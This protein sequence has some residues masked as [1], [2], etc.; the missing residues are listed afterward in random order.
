[1]GE[2]AGFLAVC[3]FL[4]VALLA[5]SGFCDE[6]DAL[7]D[8][9][10][11][12]SGLSGQLESFAPAV[13]SAVPDDAFPNAKTKAEIGASMKKTVGKDRL[14]PL[15]REA[16]RENFDREMIEQ[17]IAFYD[18]KL[19][20]K[21]GRLQGN[22]LAPALLKTVREGRKTTAAM[23]E[24]RLNLLRR[25]IKAE[26]VAQYNQM[27]LQSFVK[28]LIDAAQNAQGSYDPKSRAGLEGI[29]KGIRFDEARTEEIALVALT[30]AYRSLDDKELEE[31]AAHKESK[32][33]VWFGSTLQKGL[34]KAAYE[35]GKAL[36]E[37]AHKS[38]KR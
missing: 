25:I 22:I 2:W 1:M 29:E 14:L 24:T 6:T 18:S 13:L 17:V 4:W 7:I 34:D 15:V 10:L 27:L 26:S 28:G 20:R 8:K 36:G 5:P 11:D 35:T 16:V 30:H 3:S 12:Q 9:A 23:D 32:A 31:L 33:G 37:A 38:G 21:V 19:G